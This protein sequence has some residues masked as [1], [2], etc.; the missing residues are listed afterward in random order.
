MLPSK[1]VLELSP[2]QFAYLQRVVERDIE[3][4]QA[5]LLTEEC[6]ATQDELD[7]AHRMQRFLRKVEQ[8]QVY[9][10]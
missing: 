6:D 2:G 7:C 9:T 1:V 10:H 5:I 8:T 4:A 3:D